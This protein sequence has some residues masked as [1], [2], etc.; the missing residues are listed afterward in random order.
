MR[1]NCKC[2]KYVSKISNQGEKIIIESKKRK[3]M[4]E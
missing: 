2:N 1:E 4:E 3:G